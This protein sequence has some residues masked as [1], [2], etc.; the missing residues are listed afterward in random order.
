MGDRLLRG[1]VHTGTPSSPPGDGASDPRRRPRSLLQPRGPRPVAPAGET[2]PG[3]L[4]AANKRARRR[5]RRAVGAAVD[6]AVASRRAVEERSAPSK[7][8]IQ[9]LIFPFQSLCPASA[10][11]CPVPPDRSPAL[12]RPQDPG[13]AT[14][15]P[16]DRA[17][18]PAGPGRQG[19]R[20]HAAPRPPATGRFVPRPPSAPNPRRPVREP[21]RPA[22]KLCQGK[23]RLCAQRGPG[24]SAHS[25][26]I[27]PHR[28]GPRGPHTAG[29][30]VV[31]CSSAPPQARASTLP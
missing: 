1:A 21:P 8:R 19:L 18:G 7:P 22:T 13:R 15:P 30:D 31:V 26:A 14:W 27:C 10:L 17:A 2:P 11:T 12:A 9:N 6:L 29:P 23:S 16:G 24:P 25:P 28:R 5:Q 4:L 3:P 20:R